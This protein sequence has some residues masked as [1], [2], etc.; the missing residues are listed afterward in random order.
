MA[1]LPKRHRTKWHPFV[2]ATVHSHGS[3]TIV[4]VEMRS[5]CP[6]HVPVL[7]RHRTSPDTRVVVMQHIMSKTVWLIYQWQSIFLS[8]NPPTEHH[9]AL[10]TSHGQNHLVATKCFTSSWTNRYQ[11]QH[12]YFQVTS[13]HLVARTFV[14]CLFVCLSVCLSVCVGRRRK[15]NTR[16]L[17]S[18]SRLRE[19]CACILRVCVDRFEERANSRM[20]CL[21]A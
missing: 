2:I 12:W 16:H 4:M 13:S 5:A 19:S 15:N 1:S 10:P 11:V 18:P 9:Q 20:V 14:C 3:N 6:S 21:W 7:I 8:R 17:C